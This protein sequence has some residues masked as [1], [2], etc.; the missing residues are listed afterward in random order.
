MT[1]TEAGWKPVAPLTHTV[2][3][4]PAAVDCPH[5]APFPQKRVLRASG[6]LNWNVG[7]AAATMSHV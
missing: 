6:N 2:V 1:E 3:S 4:A 5:T 7:M